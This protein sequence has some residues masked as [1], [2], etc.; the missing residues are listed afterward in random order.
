[1]KFKTCTE[2]SHKTGVTSQENK[3]VQNKP[4]DGVVVT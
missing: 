2:S 3:Q 4:E 1:M